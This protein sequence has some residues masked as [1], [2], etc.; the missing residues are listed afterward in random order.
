MS[1]A[2]AEV[3]LAAS[4]VMNA[5]LLLFLAGVLRK[6]MN[7][8]S[9]SSFK[10]FLDSLVRYSKNSP[11]MLFAFNIPLLGAIPYFYFYGFANRWL[12]TA[13]I[14]WFVAGSIAK[15]VKLPIYKA[16]ADS[17]PNDTATLSAARQRM[18]IANQLQAASNSL[19]A[20]LA[21]VPYFR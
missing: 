10:V 14:V 9:E 8:L 12:L 17:D 4:L 2:S 7:D 15:I 11:F 6:T 1:R 18:N 21:L 19:A 5:A 3:L 16:V 13:L 20:L